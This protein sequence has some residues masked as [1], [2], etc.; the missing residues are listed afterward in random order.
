MVM[1]AYLPGTHRDARAD[2]PRARRVQRRHLA[3][4]PV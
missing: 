3:D 4:G 1:P 2:H